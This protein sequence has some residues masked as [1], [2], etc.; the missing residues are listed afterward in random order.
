[1][2]AGYLGHPDWLLRLHAAWAVGAIGGRDADRVIDAALE[3]EAHQEVRGELAI[4]RS[5]T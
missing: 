3:F 5:S 1:V 4:A 2:L